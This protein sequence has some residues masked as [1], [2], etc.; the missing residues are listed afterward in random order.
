MINVFDRIFKI[1]RKDFLHEKKGKNYLLDVFLLVI[2]IIIIKET[3][4]Q[5]I[6]M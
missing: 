2:I 5:D 4:K 3:D 6:K 1:I